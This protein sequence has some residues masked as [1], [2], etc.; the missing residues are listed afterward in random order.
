MLK[1]ENPD[2]YLRVAE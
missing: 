2:F 1:S